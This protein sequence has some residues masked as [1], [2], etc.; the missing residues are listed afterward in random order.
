[1]DTEGSRMREPQKHNLK[2]HLQEVIKRNPD[3]VEVYLFGSRAY[4][5]GSLRSDC[6]LLVRV[7]ETGRVKYSD[8]RDYAVEKCP[9]LDFFVATG[10]RAYSCANESSVAAPT[11]EDLVKKLDGILLW[12]KDGGFSNF[13]FSMQSKWVFDTLRQSKFPASSLPDFAL[14][15]DTWKDVMKKTEAERL[16]VRPFM[17]DTLDKVVAQITD[18]A[19]KMVMKPE[20]LGGNGVGRA[21]WTVNLQTEYDCQNLFWTVVKPWI[22]E[23]SKEPVIIRYQKQEKR[24]DFAMV[25]GRLVIELKYIE[26]ETKKRE[27]LKD[28]AGLSDFYQRNGNIRCLLLLIYYREEAV[29][30]AMQLESDYSFFHTRPSVIAHLIKLP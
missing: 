8:L 16:P 12:S 28:L 27:V 5:T 19:R 25:D 26:S 29:I 2:L 22:P 14:W 10:G 21:G 13:E 18:V 9:P 24:A 7:S 30:D 4:N 1:M 17:G 20:D 15:D 23:L 3:I 11:F 6:D